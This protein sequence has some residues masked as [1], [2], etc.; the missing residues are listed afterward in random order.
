MVD[1]V[2]YYMKNVR[3]AALSIKKFRKEVE[4]RPGWSYAGQRDG[5]RHVFKYAPAENCS[6]RGCC[7][8][9]TLTT[10]HSGE[11][12]WHRQAMRDIKK[13]EAKHPMPTEED[14]NKETKTSSWKERYFN[15]L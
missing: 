8:Y 7:N 15:N 9:G 11:E 5:Q 6:V 12:N 2:N 1:F 4:K 10:S 13:M 14:D 3:T